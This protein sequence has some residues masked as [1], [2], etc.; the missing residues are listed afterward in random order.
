MATGLV[1]REPVS[2]QYRAGGLVAQDRIYNFGIPKIILNSVSRAFRLATKIPVAM[3]V[4]ALLFACV[5]S[6]YAADWSTPEQQLARKIFA[7]TGAGAASLSF[8]NRSSLG[9]RDSEIIQNGLRST[10]EN[11]GL[12]FA[13]DGTA[14]NITISLSENLNSYVWVAE[15]KSQTGDSSVVMVSIPRPASFTTH[16]SVPLTL[17]KISVWEQSEPILDVAV[18]EENTVPSRI[19]VLGPERLSLY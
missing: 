9:R 1:A 16:D 6:S 10:L 4:L 2:K 18:L 19:A 8:D 13:P 7:V 14:S 15:M 17:R 3:R 11:M 12:R 5:F